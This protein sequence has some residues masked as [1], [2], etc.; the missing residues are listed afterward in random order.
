[1]GQV[2]TDSRP[3]GPEY[4]PAVEK[5]KPFAVRADQQMIEPVHRM[6]HPVM[7]E[8]LHHLRKR[9][10][11]PGTVPFNI[12]EP[13]AVEVR[14]SMPHSGIVQPGISVSGAFSVQPDEIQT[15]SPFAVGAQAV[16]RAAQGAARAGDE[17]MN[18]GD[19]SVPLK[20]IVND[21]VARKPL[22]HGPLLPV[23]R[24]SFSNGCKIISFDDA[25]QRLIP[26]TR[27]TGGESDLVNQN[28]FIF[29]IRCEFIEIPEE[30]VS[31]RRRH[32]FRRQMFL[33][34]RL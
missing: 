19:I 32:R 25:D 8:Q 33:N 15:Q 21:T 17:I 6:I 26:Q 9:N 12:D 7:R 18:A 1:M 29:F 14:I 4:A 27:L 31:V 30:T 28:P 24:Q 5:S 23:P 2:R 20:I 16:D 13:D 3:P 10:N 22:E 34:N 11:Q